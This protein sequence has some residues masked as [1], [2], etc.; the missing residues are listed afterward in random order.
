MLENRSAGIGFN[1]SS[2]SDT[3]GDGDY[4]WP[5]LDPDCSN[6]AADT[7]KLLEN[8]TRWVSQEKHRIFL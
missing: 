1:S 2:L 4:L 3:E 6:L 5:I 7:E 8:E